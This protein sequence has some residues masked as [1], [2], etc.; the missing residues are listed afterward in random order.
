MICMVSYM[1]LVWLQRSGDMGYFKKKLQLIF[2]LYHRNEAYKMKQ[3]T[4]ILQIN[5]I[6]VF[7]AI[8]F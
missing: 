4:L 1:I 5:Q 2:F 6:V 7:W 8:F 3:L